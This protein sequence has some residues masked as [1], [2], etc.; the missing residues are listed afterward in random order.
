MEFGI[1]WC[2]TPP[3][4]LARDDLSHG[5][6]L[7]VGRVLG[8]LGEGGFCYASNAWL[9]KQLHL[10]GNRVSRL[11]SHLVSLNILRLE[12]IKDQ[13]QKVVERRLYPCG[14]LLNLTGGIVEND[15][16]GIVENKQYSNR[17]KSNRDENNI[18]AK[19]QGETVSLP[20]KGIQGVA[21]V[22]MD[23]LK[24][25]QSKPQITTTYEWQDKALRYAKDLGINW[26][27]KILI[28][29]RVKARWMSLFKRG[30][31]VDKAYSFVVDYNTP[32]N[33][34]EKI[35]LFFWKVS[36]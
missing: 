6:M 19:A 30:I 1:G 18:L 3:T 8:L 26:D 25:K 23:S 10:T 12:L 4:I 9:G 35:K 17:D 34:H 33:S 7:L 27:D 14:V 28:E 32:L 31:G 15:N 21:S 11:V 5:E 2:L 16:R 36:H 13:N 22:L 24:S 29:N 20:R